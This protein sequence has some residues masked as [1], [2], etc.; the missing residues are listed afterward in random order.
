MKVA[1]N[2]CFDYCIMMMKIQQTEGLQY[3][4]D[5]DCY[6]DKDDGGGDDGE[7]PDEMKEPQANSDVF[8]AKLDQIV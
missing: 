3:N 6:D 1:I 2:C 7:Y 8:V 4:Y 5:S